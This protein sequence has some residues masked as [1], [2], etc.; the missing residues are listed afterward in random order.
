M[1]KQAKG[2][3]TSM[4]I[5]ISYL[6]G[7][8]SG[9][10]MFI[11]T[12]FL[13]IIIALILFSREKLHKIVE[14][15]NEKEVGDLLEFLI[16]LGIIYPM[17]PEEAVVLGITVPLFTMWLLVVFISLV[18]FA[19]FIF[20]RK[21]RTRY[22]IEAISILGG[23]V[24]STAT[25]VS[26]LD[27]YK[28]N[29]K[30]LPSM[31]GSFLLLNAASFARNLMIIMIAVPSAGLVVALPAVIAICV[32]VYYG[33]K[34][35]GE[36]PAKRLKIDSPF[37]VKRGVKL[38]IAIAA[39]FIVLDFMKFSG[40]NFFIIFSFLGGIAE[41]SATFVSIASMHAG[42]AITIKTLALAA[43]MAQT[44]GFLG[45]ALVCRAYGGKEVLKKAMVPFA[46]AI[47]SS[48]VTLFVLI[49]I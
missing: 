15:L 27:I 18:N 19:A 41:T 20:A 8:L 47:A 28:N 5:I 31:A 11:E 16:V 9:Y 24:S 17:I 46:L 42:S 25:L 36:K 1:K 35:A 30:M 13:S 40:M 12:I 39:M 22:E 38:A 29:R 21:M 34:N 6:L 33:L 4:A 45:N 44:G 43:V 14:N 49:L 37:N 10:G 3:T 2:F 48:F 26:M 7:V 32:L 23:L